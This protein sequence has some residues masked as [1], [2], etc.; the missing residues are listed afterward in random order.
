MAIIAGVSILAITFMA[1][2]FV[3]ICTEGSRVKVCEVLRLDTESC[4]LP[5]A[6]HQKVETEPQG[7]SADP[8]YVPGNVVVM[9][10]ARAR[11]RI[12]HVRSRKPA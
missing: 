3:K 1:V 9:P 8:G 4:A 5:D 2:F 10:E 7:P 6:V 11:D 12:N